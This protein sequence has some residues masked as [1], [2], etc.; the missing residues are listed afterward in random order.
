MTAASPALSSFARAADEL[1]EQEFSRLSSA[2]VP[3]VESLRLLGG[4]QL[5][6]ADLVAIKDGKR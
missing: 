3:T 2:V 4:K 1:R 5:R 6:A